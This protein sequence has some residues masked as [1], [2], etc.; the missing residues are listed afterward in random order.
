MHNKTP[1]HLVPENTNRLFFSQ[2]YEW[3]GWFCGSGW[4]LFM[5]LFGFTYWVGWGLADPGPIGWDQFCSVPYDLSSSCRLPRLILIGLWV[6]REE[7]K[8]CCFFFKPL[9]LS[10]LLASYWPRKV[11]WLSKYQANKAF[12]AREIMSPRAWIQ[13][14]HSGAIIF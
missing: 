8:M 5:H 3:S 6:L 10:S 14:R 11:T 4:G 1:P 7:A 13:E 12:D 9:L 2:V